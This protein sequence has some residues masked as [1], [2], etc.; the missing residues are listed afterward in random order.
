MLE[1]AFRPLPREY[2][3]A[4]QS[5]FSRTARLRGKQ[6]DQV[7]VSSG[8][9]GIELYAQQYLEPGKWERWCIRPSC[10]DSLEV[11][12]STMLSW[13]RQVIGNR[14]AIEVY[15]PDGEILDRAPFRWFWLLPD[16]RVPEE[17]NLKF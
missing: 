11:S 13:L 17:F 1:V 15:P 6:P 9:N 12:W 14:A 2:W 16:N 4:H 8:L 7:F 5:M 3:D 10:E